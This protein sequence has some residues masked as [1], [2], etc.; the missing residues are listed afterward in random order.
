VR[1]NAGKAFALRIGVS[2]TQ[3]STHSVFIV[4][5]IRI[6]DSAEPKGR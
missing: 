5:I 6:S 1:I 3:S 2:A 4:G